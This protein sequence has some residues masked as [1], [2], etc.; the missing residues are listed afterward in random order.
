MG[1]INGLTSVRLRT[2]QIQLVIGHVILGAVLPVDKYR[3]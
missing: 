3:V 1:N 2:E